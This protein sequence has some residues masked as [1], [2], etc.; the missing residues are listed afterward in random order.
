VLSVLTLPRGTEF[1]H[2]VC[3]VL[4]CVLCCILLV[5]ID[6]TVTLQLESALMGG[7]NGSLSNET[8]V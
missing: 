1:R 2:A 5:W 4:C 6:V 7:R 3:C 8:A